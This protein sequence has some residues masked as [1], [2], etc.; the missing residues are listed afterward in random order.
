MATAVEHIDQISDFINGTE[1]LSLKTAPENKL[2]IHQKTDGK[3]LTLS[4]DQIEEIISRVDSGNHSFL[5]V[6]FNSGKKIL[7]TE[8]LVGFKP[9]KTTDLDMTKIPKVVTTPDL[10]SVVEAIEE[11]IH[12]T[13]THPEEVNVLKRVFDSVLRG[14]ED[15]GFDLNSE[16]TWLNMLTNTKIK[17]TA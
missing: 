7:I 14:G 6:N 15:I 3:H 12:S 5:Q 9:A 13:E 10:L 2:V 4:V 16:R 17:P 1:G 11:S 8:K